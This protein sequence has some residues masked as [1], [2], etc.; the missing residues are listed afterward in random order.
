MSMEDTLDGFKAFLAAGLE[1][2]L[3]AIEAAR[4]VTIPRCLSADIDTGF[5]ESGQVPNISIVPADTVPDYAEGDVLVEP[6]WD[7]NVSV[8]IEHAG[9]PQK[10]V[11]YVLLRYAEALTGMIIADYT[12]G[13]RVELCQ[14]EG[15]SYSLIDARDERAIRQV[16]DLRLLIREY[17]ST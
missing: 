15:I 5:V 12:C 17:R 6:W 11:Q 8:L 13:S 10:T 1:T 7:D 9:T 16:T 14:V 2:K 4:S 3:L